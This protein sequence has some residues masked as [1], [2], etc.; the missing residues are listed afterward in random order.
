[1]QEFEHVMLRGAYGAWDTQ[2][3]PSH[4]QG[5]TQGCL[6]EPC[7]V[8]NQTWLG[9]MPGSIPN[10]STISGLLFLLVF[11]KK[12]FGGEVGYT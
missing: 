3:K 11:L 12:F 6:G 9:P 2:A 1:M 4:H 10:H 8:V 7:G 5:H